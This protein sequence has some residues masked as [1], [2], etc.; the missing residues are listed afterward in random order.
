VQTQRHREVVF[1]F[2]L[3]SE[4]PP[5]FLE[6]VLCVNVQPDGAKMNSSHF[7]AVNS[8]Q[9][10]FQVRFFLVLPMTYSALEISTI[11]VNRYDVSL[12]LGLGTKHAQADLALE[13]VPSAV[14]YSYVFI[15]VSIL[16][17]GLLAVPARIVLPLPVNRHAMSFEIMDSSEAHTAQFTHFRAP[18]RPR[19]PFTV[20]LNMVQSLVRLLFIG[21]LSSSV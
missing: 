9:V 18:L 14:R 4:E 6:E 16:S 19:Q 10:L 13:H 8:L 15:Q 1:F 3:T 20:L 12:Q 7:L 2:M 11:L 5:S 21:Y 17:E